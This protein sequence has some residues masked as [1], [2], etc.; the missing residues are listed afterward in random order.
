MGARHCSVCSIRLPGVGGR[1]LNRRIAVVAGVVALVYVVAIVAGLRVRKANFFD[2]FEG[3]KVRGA[4]TPP[5]LSEADEEVRRG[6]LIFNETP[7]YA[8]KFVGGKLS[9][10][11]C[12]AEG[13]TQPL[14]SPMVGVPASF[15]QFNARAGHVISLEDRIQECFVRSENGRPLDYKGSEMRGLVA[16]IQWLSKP[17]AGAE[18]FVGRGF[19]ALP[20]LAPD[21]K[22]GEGIYARQ[23]AGCHGTNGEGKPLTFPPLWGPDSFNDGAGMN[24]VKRMAAFVHAQPRPVFNVAYKGY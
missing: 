10:G 16:Y 22:R 11:S 4:W 19:V 1:L 3:A 8:G 23:C 20:D 18:K 2:Y 5:K 15:P 17:R 13:G 21:A 6:A 14:A 9:C 7:L 24:G 12:H